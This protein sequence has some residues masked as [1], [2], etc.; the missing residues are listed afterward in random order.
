MSLMRVDPSLIG[1]LVVRIGAR[2]IDSSIKTNLMA[3]ISYEG[4]CVMDIRAAEISAIPKDQIT[5]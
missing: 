1:G 5:G 3:G 2:M 4:C